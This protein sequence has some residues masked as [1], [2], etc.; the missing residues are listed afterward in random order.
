[1]TY[2]Q[3]E[4]ELITLDLIDIFCTSDETLIPG[5]EDELEDSIIWPK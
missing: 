5:V 1:M 3:P 4:L 2:I